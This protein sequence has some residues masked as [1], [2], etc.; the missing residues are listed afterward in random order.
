MSAFV[1]YVTVHQRGIADE[2]PH[3]LFGE[4]R[5]ERQVST[6]ETMAGQASFAHLPNGSLHYRET[7]LLQAAGREFEFQRSYLYS[8]DRETL[9]IDFDEMPA[10]FFQIVPLS[11]TQLGWEGQG[12]RVCGEDVYRSLYRFISAASF[13]IVHAVD[14]PRKRQEITTNYL[15]EAA[16]RPRED[17]E[18]RKARGAQ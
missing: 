6:G 14:G 17:V 18:R 1:N 8:F 10:R 4:W 5:L 15:R 2:L 3:W 9:R 13:S 11:A 16:R 12:R 7:G